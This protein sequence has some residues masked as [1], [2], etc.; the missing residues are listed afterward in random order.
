MEY[1]CA[2]GQMFRALPA[3]S[4]ICQYR[5][6]TLPEDA[7]YVAVSTHPGSSERR[8]LASEPVLFAGELSGGCTVVIV[9]TQGNDH[10]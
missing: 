2:V 4:G 7:L 10:L 6:D 8:A 9:K 5:R 1:E 3:L